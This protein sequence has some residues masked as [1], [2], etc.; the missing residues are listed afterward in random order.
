[1]TDSLLSRVLVPLDGSPNAEIIL[2][3]LRRFL[4]RPQSSLT[5]L[6]ALPLLHGTSEEEAT[7]YL[8]ALAARLTME[9]HP[10]KDLVR[11]GSAGRARAWRYWASSCT[12][13]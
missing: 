12:R 8:R 2:P 11:H 1:M 3:Q 10:S 5:L 6:Q 7:L 13:R 4:T 9:G